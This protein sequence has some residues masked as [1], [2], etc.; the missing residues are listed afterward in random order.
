MGRVAGVLRE[1]PGWERIYLVRPATNLAAVSHVLILRGG[2]D[3]AVDAAFR[4]G[5]P[6]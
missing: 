3:H 2:A 6:P 5:T 1:Q 4:P